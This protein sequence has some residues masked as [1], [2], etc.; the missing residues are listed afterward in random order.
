MLEL[1]CIICRIFDFSPSNMSHIRTK[2]IIT[3]SI[4][5]RTN[6]VGTKT[7]QQDRKQNVVYLQGLKKN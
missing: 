7:K 1:I 2:M 4:P 3:G 5:I 6:F